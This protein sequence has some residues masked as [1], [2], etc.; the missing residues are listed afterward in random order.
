LTEACIPALTVNGVTVDFDAGWLQDASGTEIELRPQSFAVLRRLAQNP[1]A[2]VTK[3]ALVEA[4]W[5]NVAVTDDSLVQC[6]GDVRRALRDDAKVVLKTVPRR[7]YRLDLPGVPAAARKR[8]TATLVAPLAVLI[9]LALVYWRQ[10]SQ[11]SATE[12]PSVAVL[13][14]DD[15]SPEAELD[16]LG[17]GVAEEIIGM[18]GRSP[19]VRVIARNSSFAYGAEPV[20]VRRIGEELGV[21]YVL[22]GSLRQEGDRLRITA[23]LADADTGDHVW[24][25]AFDQV[26]VNPIPLQ[27]EV[28]AR[29][30]SALAGERGALRMRLF[31][32]AWARDSTSLDEYS[33]YLRA[34]DLMHG[35]YSKET[36][37]ESARVAL[38]GL[39]AFPDSPLLK[40]ILA[41]THWRSAYNFWSDDPPA[42]YAS[43]GRLTREVLALPNLT[44]RVALKANW[45]FA[46]VTLSEGKHELALDQVQK[47]LALAP[48]DPFVAAEIAEI[49][50]PLGEYDE[51]LRLLDFAEKGDPLSADY[52]GIL[53]GWIHRLQGDLDRSVAELA[54]VSGWGV[55]GGMQYAISL[56]Q[57]DRP[58]DARAELR[59]VL[60]EVPGMTQARWRQAVFYRD[61]ALLEAELADLAATGLPER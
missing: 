15:M 14:F 27:G 24:A 8:P 17:A 43:A 18:L 31:R 32:E 60:A 51:A 7:G 20:D 46:Y 35:H 4:V 44:P 47:A 36:N 55:W 58:D 22:D 5:P 25:E 26:G 53:R 59:K 9:V 57:A 11:V 16:D 19:D 2:V 39:D 12:L 13:P 21:G 6:I 30:V 54:E 34:V 38:A 52:H 29:I 61:E 40:I 10:A 56:T 1:G 3:D 45:L 41:W 23:Q 37:A 28:T 33:Y 48:Y 50:T 42:D 49:L